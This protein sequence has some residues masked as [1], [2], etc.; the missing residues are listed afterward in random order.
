MGQEQTQFKPKDAHWNWKGGISLDRKEYMTPYLK[1][2]YEEHKMEIN[3]ERQTEEYKSKKRVWDKNYCR[4]H[5]TKLSEKAKVYY[6]GNKQ[7]IIGAHKTQAGKYAEYKR[8]AKNRGIIFAISFDEYI[9]LCWG[10]ICHYCGEVNETHGMDRVDNSKGYI[11]E[12]L[13]SCCQIC[14]WM[15]RDLGLKDFIAH[16][17][18]ITIK[19][20][21]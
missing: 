21:G 8:G 16:C 19:S 14:N 9:A 17:H 12:N 20:G 15:K 2:Y 4:K 3:T 13:V 11:L 10:V 5:C 7:R 1:K 18:K 6:L